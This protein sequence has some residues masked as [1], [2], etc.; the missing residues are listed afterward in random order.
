[1]NKNTNL[2]PDLMF[3]KYEY[4]YTLLEDGRSIA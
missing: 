2:V 4:K 1:M 3:D